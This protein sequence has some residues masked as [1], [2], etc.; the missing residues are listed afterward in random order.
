[1]Y[2]GSKIFLVGESFL[3][4]SW[5]VQIATEPNI[6]HGQQIKIRK[7]SVCLLEFTHH[8]TQKDFLDK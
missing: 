6:L 2:N 8:W 3:I 4:V 1:M 5:K 7:L